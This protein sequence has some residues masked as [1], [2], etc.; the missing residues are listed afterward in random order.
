M[1]DGGTASSSPRRTRAAALRWQVGV[2]GG[3][4]AFFFVKYKAGFEKRELS[5]VTG[6]PVGS[7][8]FWIGKDFAR[9]QDE[10]DFYETAKLFMVRALVIAVRIRMNLGGLTTMTLI[11]Q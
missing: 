11:P 1:A 10:V 3:T 7:R 6:K 5:P 8:D 2:S 4:A 9:A